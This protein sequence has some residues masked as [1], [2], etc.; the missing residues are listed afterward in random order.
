MADITYCSCL[1]CLNKECERHPM[2]II[3]AAQSRVK[4]VSVADLSGTCRDYIHQVLIEVERRAD[5]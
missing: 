1:E 2:E 3:K 5:T 4:L